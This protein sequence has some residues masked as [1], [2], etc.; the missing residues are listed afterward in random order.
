MIMTTSHFEQMPGKRPVNPCQQLGKAV[1]RAYFFGFQ[2]FYWSIQRP[3]ST[4]YP[5]KLPL[6]A[7]AETS[8]GKIHRKSH[9]VTGAVGGPVPLSRPFPGITKRKGGG[10]SDQPAVTK[11]P[12]KFSFLIFTSLTLIFELQS[13]ICFYM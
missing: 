8:E 12:K 5:P 2:Q 6:L 9:R 4:N 11:F 7:S 3:V 10:L 13:H 1:G